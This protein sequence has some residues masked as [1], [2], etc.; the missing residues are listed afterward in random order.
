MYQA[1]ILNALKRHQTKN[2]LSAHMP[3][4]KNGAIVAENLRTAWGSDIFRY[5]I[6]ELDG[7]DDLH[8]PS[9]IIAQS[10]KQA[11]EIFHA[12][13][14]CYLINGSTV[15]LHAAL[16]SAARGEE[17][18]IPRHCHRSVYYGLMLAQAKPVFLPITLDPVW[19]IPLGVAPADLKK[20]ISAHP[21]CHNLLIVNPTY[22]GI[23]WQN[24]DLMKIAK[25][26]NLT[27]IV[28]EAHGA[29][30]SFHPALPPSMLSL[31]ADLVI[32][33][34]HKTLPAL[35]GSS[36]LLIGENYRGN[37][38]NIALDILQ[39]TSPSYLMLSALESAAIYM[40]EHG[41]SDIAASLD[42]IAL[43]NEEIFRLETIQALQNPHWHQDPFKLNLSSR[44]LSGAEL[45]QKLA[46]H[47]IYVEMSEAN[48]VLLLLPL[49]ITPAYREA[50]VSALSEIDASCLALPERTL[51]APFYL[52]QVP[53]KAVSLAEALWQEKKA[54]PLA[55]ANGAISAEFLLKY[56]PGIPIALPGEIITAEIVELLRRDG[57]FA[58]IN[59][60]K[61]NT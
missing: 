21:N 25:E 12:K 52:P 44:A 17:I 37:D 57:N 3:G 43:L 11:A 47:Q 32:Q 51:I 20:A 27:V 38:V 58:A 59:V 19:G 29:H 18:F 36:C 31:D 6:T 13:E 15:G 34:W 35:T 60:L 55:E 8:H 9:G 1:Y 54:V 49:K 30:L 7:M 24:S 26:N 16:L 48:S 23:T 40:A 46:A 42:E 10:Q 45:A 56:P 5:D 41:E 2:P 14:A 53:P 61:T 39:S 4:H 50:L 28:D 33:S 22:H